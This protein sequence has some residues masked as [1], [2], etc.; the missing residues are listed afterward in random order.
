[1]TKCSLSSHFQIMSDTLI[2]SMEQGKFWIIWEQKESS[3]ILL[4]FTSQT[5]FFEC[6]QK[7]CDTWSSRTVVGTHGF[8]ILCPHFERSE[9]KRDL[10][11]YSQSFCNPEGDFW[12]FMDTLGGTALWSGIVNLLETFCVHWGDLYFGH[13]EVLKDYWLVRHLWNQWK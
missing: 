3:C 12:T 10:I 2:S 4:T 5:L 6:V 7:L 13:S 8:P 11:E 1:M 9:H